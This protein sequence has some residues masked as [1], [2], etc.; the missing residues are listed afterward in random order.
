M[1][2]KVNFELDRIDVKMQLYFGAGAM[3]RKLIAGGLIVGIVGG[4][5]LVDAAYIIKLKN[6][7]EYVTGRYWQAGTQVL[8]DTY[9]GVFGIDRSFVSKIEKTDQPMRLA[10][11]RESNPA[12]PN[13]ELVEAKPATETKTEEKRDPEDPI[14]GEFNRLKAKSKE[15]DSM[16][17][18][19]IRDLLREIKAFKDKISG[20]SKLFVSY[21]REFNDV[22]EVGSVVES[23]LQS[24][25]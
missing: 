10:R 3:M 23:A 21:G 5:G 9:G 6:G 2:R 19:E 16:L 11:V 22:H 17:T 24:R 4:T 8:F 14:V 12:K 25:R 1:T 20:D 7:N 13:K 15:V 18:S